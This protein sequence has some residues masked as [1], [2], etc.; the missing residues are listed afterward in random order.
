VP[1]TI[2]KIAH[3][4]LLEFPLAGK[5]LCTLW[6][7]NRFLQLADLRNW[8]WRYKFSEFGIP[9]AYSTGTVTIT[10][11]DPTLLIGNGTAWTP[12]M[13]GMQLIIGYS[14]GYDLIEF[15]DST[16]MR[17]SMPWLDVDQIAIGYQFRQQYVTPPADFL[18]FDSILYPTRNYKIRHGV[19]RREIDR[20]D[21]RR[22]TTGI[23]YVVAEAGY[24]PAFAGTI[25]ATPFAANAVG[26]PPPVFGGQFSGPADT[27]F[28]VQ[29][30]V[31]GDTGSSTFQWWRGN[32]PLSPVTVTDPNGV[33]LSS[34]IIVYFPHIPSGPLYSPGDVFVSR[35][36]SVP[37]FGI[38]RFELWPVQLTQSVYPYYYLAQPPDL[39]AI[40]N[41]T[42]PATIPGHA[43]LEGMRADAAAWPGRGSEVNKYYDLK[44]V[45]VHEAKFTRWVDLLALKDDEIYP[46]DVSYYRDLPF[47]G[48]PWDAAWE[49]R[50]Q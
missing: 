42:L 39:S 10:S 27:L 50:H 47:A 41:G 2:D 44:A 25:D 23:P 18:S 40:A 4:G 29:I 9:S 37:S 1:D 26:G 3:Q 24:G 15:I 32:G 19:E 35:A 17:I 38:P 6:A 31:G 33:A 46:K 22:T 11:A 45:A 48:P 43:I 20:R 7:S 21:P 36:K 30:V 49:Q 8:S 12:S 34:G 14:F 28:F 16:H 13:V 5:P